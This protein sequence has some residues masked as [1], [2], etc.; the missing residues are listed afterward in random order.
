M[1]AGDTTSHAEE[2]TAFVGWMLWNIVRSHHVSRGVAWP[3]DDH[4][5]IFNNMPQDMQ[6][7]WDRAAADL[8]QRA[9]GYGRLI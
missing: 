6:T 3:Q 4:G 9:K 1:S 8:Q 2:G 7:A 5:G